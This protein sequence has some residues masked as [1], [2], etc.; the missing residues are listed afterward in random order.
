[1]KVRVEMAEVIILTR[2]DGYGVRDNQAV[3]LNRSGR[4]LDELVADFK[5]AVPVARSLREG[6]FNEAFA[7]W[8]CAGGLSERAE[9]DEL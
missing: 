5:G 4:T 1:M 7:D 3:L 9:W 2:E 8:A 6:E